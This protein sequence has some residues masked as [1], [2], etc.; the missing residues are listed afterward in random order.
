[1]ALAAV[2]HYRVAGPLTAG[3]LFWAS[4]R[5]GKSWRRLREG[6]PAKAAHLPKESDFNILGQRTSDGKNL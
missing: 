3:H 6:A 5:I 1:M 2:G 4:D